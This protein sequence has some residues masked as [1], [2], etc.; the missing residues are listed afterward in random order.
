MALLVSDEGEAWANLGVSQVTLAALATRSLDAPDS[1]D[2]LDRGTDDF[3][4]I[5]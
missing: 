2:A 4:A 3:A 1:F 5:L